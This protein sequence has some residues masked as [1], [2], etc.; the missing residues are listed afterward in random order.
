MQKRFRWL[1]PVTLLFILGLLSVAAE[2]IELPTCPDTTLGETAEDCPWAAVAKA[3]EERAQRRGSLRQ[4]L[5]ELVPGLMD[6]IHRDARR[7]DWKKLWG[8]SLNYD[9]YAKGII[10]DPAILDA[11]AKEMQ[12]PPRNER[13]VHAGMEHIYG[14]LFST[15]KTSFGYKRARW[16]RDDIEVGFGLPRGTLGPSPREGTLFSNATFFFGKIAFRDAG[17]ELKQI[18]QGEIGVASELR[19]MPYADLKILRL[20]ETVLDGKVAFRTDFVPFLNQLEGKSNTHLLIYSVREGD[21][22]QLIT[23]FPVAQGFVDSALKAENL[24]EGRD[25]ISR[26]NAYVNGVTGVTPPLKGTRKLWP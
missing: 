1:F 19:S 13:I 2:A 7:P 21:R 25:V 11:L 3:L 14:Y 10:V 26:Y 5:K 23:A 24:G 18:V 9:E 4:P 15:L 6:Q 17:R 16:V 8:R 20:E 22:V 12:V